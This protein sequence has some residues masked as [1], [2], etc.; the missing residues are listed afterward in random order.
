MWERVCV[1]V[2]ARARARA[3]ELRMFANE[4]A[5]LVFGCGWCSVSVRLCVCAC[6]RVSCVEGVS[7]VCTRVCACQNM[8]ASTPLDASQIPGLTP[9][10]F[11]FAFRAWSTAE[12]QRFGLA[13]KPG[14]EP[15]QRTRS[16]KQ[17]STT[18]NKRKRG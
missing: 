17:Q 10:S 15:E 18:S 2:R 8:D 9:A 6:L 5:C 3:C 16:G 14:P 12:A 4:C 11:M 13:A 1:S 7:C